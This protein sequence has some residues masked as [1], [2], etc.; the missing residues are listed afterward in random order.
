M[1][2]STHPQMAATNPTAAQTE[3]GGFVPAPVFTTYDPK[4]RTD[5]LYLHPNE[6]PSLQL[7]TAPLIGRSNYHPWARAMEMALK[8]KNKMVLVD[9]SLTIPG[10]TDPKFFYWDQCNIMVLS[11][12]LRA[13]SPTIGQGVLWIN[14]AEGV[15]KDLK[16]RF[17]QQ[18]EFRVADIRS[19]IYRTK[20]DNEEQVQ[21]TTISPEIHQQHQEDI[22]TQSQ[23]VPSVQEGKTNAE[24]A[25]EPQLRRST[26]IRTIPPYLND[27][28]CQNTPVKRTSPHIISNVLSYS[29]LSQKYRAFA[30]NALNMY[31][32]IDFLTEPKEEDIS[33]DLRSHLNARIDLN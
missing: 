27:Y 5:P 28:A 10:V 15:W 6:S 2:N 23:S 9:C 32:Y 29:S 19:E 22:D 16:K 31:P 4:D 18:D 12:I 20:Q 11:W 33:S 3:N 14:T 26:R 30:V 1:M 17:S 13:V 25:V 21:D 7:V 24:S 8:S